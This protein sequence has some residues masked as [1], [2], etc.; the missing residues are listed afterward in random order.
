MSKKDKNIELDSLPQSA[1][2][3]IK[4]VIKKMGYRR[5]VRRDVQAELAA[6]FEDEL[7]DC[8]DEQQRQQKSRQIIEQFGDAKLLGI[9]LRRAKKRCRPLWRTAV[10]RFFQAVAILISCL[11]IYIA[12]FFSGKPAVTVDYVAKVNRI[13]RPVADESLNAMSLFD[14]AV[15]ACPNL[16]DRNA[17][18][19]KKPYADMNETEKET[20]SDIVRRCSASLQ[21][22]EQGIQK[23]YCWQEYSAKADS[24]GSLLSV[25]LPNLSGF[26][27]MG[28]ILCF[29]AQIQAADGQYT[30]AFNS[31]TNCYRFGRMIKQGEKTLVEQLVGIA[32]EAW[33]I[34]NIRQIMQHYEI[35]AP[36]LAQFQQEFEKACANE[37]FTMNMLVEK[38]CI[39]DEIQRCFTED[40]L[41]G[42]HLYLKRLSGLSE[43]PSPDNAEIVILLKSL[44]TQPNKAQTK[45]QLDAL[46]DF[47]EETSKMSPARLREQR[48]KGL[49]LNEQVE[50]MIKGNLFLN[51]LMPAFGAVHKIDYRIKTD[52]QSVL[53][54]TTV[55][56]CNADTGRYPQDLMEL[57]HAG[58]IN[59]IPIDPFS[60]KP[61]VYRK[62][63][64]GFTLYS[65]G[66]D[67]KDDGGILGTNDEGQ[68]TIWTDEGDAVFWPIQ[69]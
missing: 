69:D 11:I 55:L 14:E 18:I 7:R 19:W 39:Y 35:E 41:G 25:L 64:E 66:L 2:E 60:D 45:E 28:Y 16:P 3:F 40:R 37:D 67:F 68:K 48:E 51:I 36:Q 12:W 38:Y 65:V 24:D 50:S 31:L 22:I 20:V 43:G 4:L 21:L 46:Y 58:Y 17:A 53:V 54:I 5:S 42:G 49:Y 10:V 8:R 13:V 30:E 63:D 52:V 62:T 44:F 26:R 61:L 34:G 59:E 27:N 9:L 6:H 56:R 32:I 23:P 1:Q 33:A 29:R 15:A 47:I 57:K